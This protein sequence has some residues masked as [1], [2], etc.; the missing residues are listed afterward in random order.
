MIN[1]IISFPCFGYFKILYITSFLHLLFLTKSIR[2]NTWAEHRLFC[3]EIIGSEWPI[4][5]T[6]CSD[7]FWLIGPRELSTSG[8]IQKSQP[9]NVQRAPDWETQP[10]FL[11]CEIMGRMRWPSRVF[12]S[13]FDFWP[14]IKYLICL[15]G[16]SLSSTHYTKIDTPSHWLWVTCCI[17]LVFEVKRLRLKSSSFPKAECHA[18]REPA[19]DRV[20]PTACARSGIAFRQRQV[21]TFSAFKNCC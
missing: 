5:P 17:A 8:R 7:P 9:R 19:P 12:W 11:I 2:I 16:I 20:G 3:A 1:Y 18:S 14:P 6:I 4:A 13:H 21:G 10:S 15:N